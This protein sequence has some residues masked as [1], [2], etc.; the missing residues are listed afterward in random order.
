MCC[1]VYILEIL[2]YNFV[3]LFVCSLVC[4]FWHPKFQCFRHTRFTY[5]DKNDN[6]V[7]F[8]PCAQKQFLL[9]TFVLNG[10]VDVSVQSWPILYE[11]NFNFEKSV[12]IQP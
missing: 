4:L 12:V 11:S 7:G 6:F 10:S 3:C 2:I 9:R 5:V 1:N 8:R